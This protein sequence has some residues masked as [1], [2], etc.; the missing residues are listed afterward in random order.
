MDLTNKGNDVTLESSEINI[1]KFDSAISTPTIYNVT[2]TL[3][4]TE[5]S[6]AMP[7][8]CRFIEFQCLTAFDV[9]WAF[10]TG[11]VAAP[12]EPY[13]TLKSGRSYSSPQIDQETSPST[14]Y[15]ASSQAAVVVQIIVWT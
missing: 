15:F 5:Y 6:Q 3:A 13:M 12:T 9:R 10:E 4:D 14:L 11:K 8:N 1:G 2:L 7:N